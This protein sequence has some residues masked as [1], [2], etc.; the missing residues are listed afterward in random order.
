MPDRIVVAIHEPQ[1]RL[2]LSAVSERLRGALLA[3]GAATLPLEVRRVEELA[4]TAL[5]KTP[6]LGRDASA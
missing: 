1:G 4:R 2:D 5:G 6:F 3:H